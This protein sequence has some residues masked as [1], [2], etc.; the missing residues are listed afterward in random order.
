VLRTCVV[1]IVLVVANKRLYCGDQFTVI[2]FAS[3]FI[4][5]QSTQPSD[6]FGHG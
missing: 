2:A 6:S 1:I 4:E 5:P 3:A